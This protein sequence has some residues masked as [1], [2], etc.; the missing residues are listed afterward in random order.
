MKIGILTYRQYPFIS[1]NTSIGYS[2]GE[3][4]SQEYN[5]EVV[6]IGRRQDESQ[7]FINDYRGNK[8]CFLNKKIENRH[9]QKVKNIIKRYL[10]ERLFFRADAKSLKAIVK[11][12]QIDALIC[13]IAPID[14]A[15]I[16][17]RARLSIPCILYQLDPFYHYEDKIDRTKKQEF[18]KI[19]KFFQAVYTT[20][21]LMEEYK[22]DVSFNN[23]L[24]KFKVAEFPLLKP[25]PITASVE[26]DSRVVRLLYTG[27][28]YQRIRPPE[29]LLKLKSILPENY[30]IIFCGTCDSETD[31]KLLQES[32][33]VCKGRLLPDQLL[34]EYQESDIL[35]NVGNIIKT[36]MG[37]KLIGYIATGKPILNIMQFVD[38][39]ADVLREYPYALNILASK[40][41]E[42]REIIVDFLER[43]K[44]SF[45]KYKE[46]E[47]KYITYTPHY[48]AQQIMAALNKKE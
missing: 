41:C 4:L 20:D 1:A 27:A 31:F 28:F 29:I 36:Q 43:Y 33:I 12:E 8:I 23:I 32:G 40:I 35:I 47:K 18:F 16:V 26:K 15:R 10:S 30:Q 46:I 34:K 42:Q 13:V 17:Q 25:I 44:G 45:A 24:D 2:I 3:T 48:V 39:T 38:C 9:L 22:G 7:D 5:H 6:Y 37:S 19:L 14:D 11:K 21:L